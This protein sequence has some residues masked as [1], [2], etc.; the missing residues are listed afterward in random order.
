M[1]STEVLVNGRNYTFI[2]LEGTKAIQMYRRLHGVLAKPLGSAMN[3]VV[4]LADAGEIT[5]LEDMDWTAVDFEGVAGTMG[6]VFASNE[7]WS[8]LTEMLLQAS[9]NKQPVAPGGTIDDHFA[10]YLE[11]LHQVA[12]HVTA[13]NFKRAFLGVPG[14]GR[15]FQMGEEM[16]RPSET[17]SP[18][19]D[20]PL[21]VESRA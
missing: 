16:F 11:D 21:P 2:K 10:D 7:F 8:C 5:S 4:R 13:F 6:D 14:V 12:F 3:Q 19:S 18:S 1:Q 9:C 17:S 15:A 20:G